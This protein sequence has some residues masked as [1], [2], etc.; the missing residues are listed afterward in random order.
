MLLVVNKYDLIEEFIEQGHELEEFMSVEYLS[1]FAEQNNF[2]GAMCT[3][4]K[5]GVGVTE[6]IACLVRHI[7]IQEF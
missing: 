2:I 4:A 1:Q 6:A 7:L 5:T 3:S